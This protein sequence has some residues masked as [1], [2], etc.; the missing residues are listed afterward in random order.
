MDLLNRFKDTLIWSEELG[1]GFHTREP[2]TYETS[3][4]RS[5]QMRDN[6]V[7]GKLLTDARINFVRKHYALP[8]VDIGIGGGRFVEDSDG[9]GFD[10]CHDAIDWLQSQGRYWDV[11]QH[12]AEVITCWDS[13]EHIPD[14]EFLLSKVS[15]Y[16]FVSM[17]IYSD[18]EDCLK[19]KHFKPGEHLHYFTAHGLKLFMRQN[20]FE[21]VDSCGIEN[22][23]GHE[24]VYS[25]AF[26]R[27]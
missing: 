19:S 3:Y 6:T 25:F 22:E 7:I 10:V 9:L 4:F 5:Y 18:M 16:V 27:I 23:L 26:K 11:Y 14:P 12:G 13:L 8:V 15:G 21:C 1:Y 20:G 2:M 24:G 17:P